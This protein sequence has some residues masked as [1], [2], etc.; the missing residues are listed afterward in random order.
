M[1]VW[2][3]PIEEEIA[4]L[5]SYF[6]CSVNAGTAALHGSLYQTDADTDTDTDTDANADTDADANADT[7]T[8]AVY[9]AC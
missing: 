5:T 2:E 3:V 8:S 6:V 9:A 7:N 4:V 1:K